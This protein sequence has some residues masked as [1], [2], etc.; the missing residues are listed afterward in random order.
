MYSRVCCYTASK[1]NGAPS[2]TRTDTPLR[3]MAF[4]AIASTNSATGAL[5]NYLRN[6]I[7]D[8]EKYNEI[9]L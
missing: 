8:V 7:L 3:E 1:I 4:E 6:I 5:H 9:R 2:R